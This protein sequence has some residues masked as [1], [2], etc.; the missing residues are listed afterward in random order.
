[1]HH[2]VVAWYLESVI[3]PE[4]PEHLRFQEVKLMSGAKCWIPAAGC[5]WWMLGCCY[6][7]FRRWFFYLM[8][9]LGCLDEL[10]NKVLFCNTKSEDFARVGGVT[11][12]GQDLGGAL[13]FNASVS[14]ARLRIWCAVSWE[15]VTLSLAKVASSIPLRILRWFPSK[16][17]MQIRRERPV[18]SQ[19]ADS[20]HRHWSL[21]HRLVQPGGGRVFVGSG[22]EG[23]SEDRLELVGLRAYAAEYIW[24]G[25]HAGRRKC[26]GTIN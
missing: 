10:K 17:L 14:V 1:M 20:M 13:L 22:S 26:V 15:P 18:G 16:S 11:W 6:L 23:T 25:P 2:Q 21:D 24:L 5:W 4:L 9:G 3:F 8:L 12:W 7:L 19:C